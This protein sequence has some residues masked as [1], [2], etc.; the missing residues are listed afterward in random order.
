M[1]VA[2]PGAG[3][4]RAMDRKEPEFRQTDEEVKSWKIG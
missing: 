1:A 3:C 2:T 4:T